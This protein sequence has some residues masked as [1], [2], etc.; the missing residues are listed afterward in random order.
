MSWYIAVPLSVI[1]VE[2]LS[3]FCEEL[4]FEY[5]G[6]EKSTHFIAGWDEE[7]FRYFHHFPLLIDQ[8]VATEEEFKTLLKLNML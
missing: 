6:D 8:L 4:G 1:N 2:R 5:M 3:S 7:G